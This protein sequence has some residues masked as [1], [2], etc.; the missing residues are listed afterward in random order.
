MRR[1]NQ[2]GFSL[3]SVMV[4]AGLLGG[5]ALGVMQIMKN[6]TSVQSFARATQDE[7]ELSA[8]AKMIVDDSR[9]CR[10][11]IAGDGPVGSPRVPVRFRKTDI[12]EAA[13]GEG[14]DIELWLSNQKGD[15]RATP[16]I[17]AMD[18]KN[19]DAPDKS[20][21]GNLRVK[22]I[23]LVM[24]NDIG[25]SYTVSPSHS[26]LGTVILSVLKEVNGQQREIEMK[27]VVNVEMKTD[28]SGISTI[29]S[30]SKESGNVSIALVETGSGSDGLT[31]T[32]ACASLG[33]NCVK[34]FSNNYIKMGS[35]CS[36]AETCARLCATSYNQSLA[37]ITD[38]NEINN[39][40]NCNAMVGNYTTYDD[41][42]VKCAAFFTAMCN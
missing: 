35:S 9:H 27:F 36:S 34:V 14:L 20:K 17:K 31:G 25:T 33:K 10:V 28:A 26:D 12:D 40:H 15:G 42:G 29:L 38:G 23:R 7:M 1:L 8:L 2:Q 5:L 24:D 16:K 13:K 21:H 3:V 19:P 37:G 22:S 4:A 41:S 6:I 39:L 11:S 32:Q 30:C 18:P